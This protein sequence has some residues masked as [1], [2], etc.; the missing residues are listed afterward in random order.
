MGSAEGQDKGRPR[1]SLH[2][3]WSLSLSLSLKLPKSRR[4]QDQHSLSHQHASGAHSTC[5]CEVAL[6]CAPHLHRAA[7]RAAHPPTRIRR[8]QHLCMRGGAA[9]RAASAQRCTQSR[10]PTDTRQ[11]HT[12]PVHARWPC[13]SCR[14]C[15]ALHPEPRTHRHASGAHSTCACE[16]ALHCAP[17]LHSAAPRAAHPPTRVKRT[18]HL[19][20]RG[21]PALRA[22]SAQRCTQSRTPTC[23]R[24]PRW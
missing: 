7:P 24:T 8:T 13:I 3:L 10:T 9:L 19:C 17:H 2:D 1:L 11:A 14:I 18:Q 12:A 20:V 16:V 23:R 22:A 5:A 6:H 21:G 4:M 15:T